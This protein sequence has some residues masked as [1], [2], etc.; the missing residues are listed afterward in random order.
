MI[1]NLIRDFLVAHKTLAK[2][3]R[4]PYNIG[5]SGIPVIIPSSGSMGN[6][7]AI[8]LTTALTTTY[9]GCYL[10]LPANAISAGSAA[11]FYYAVMSSTTVGTVYNNTYSSGV[12][13]DP[14]SPTAFSTTGP[15][16]YTQTTAADLTLLNITIP[17]GAMGKNGL[18][19]CYPEFTFSNSAGVKNLKLLLNATTVLT[20][21]PTT[22]AYNPM[23]YFF[24]NKGANNVNMDNSG[25][26]FGAIATTP[27]RR[28][29]D[30]GADF[31]YKCVG[32]LAAATDYIVLEA[33]I[34]QL[35]PSN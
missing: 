30:T 8:T 18:L 35:N 24:R 29:I 28:T 12:P 5:Q 4:I 27:T 31:T 9:P 16:A 11:G 1:S 21:S 34:I 7:G 10:Y 26:G 15:G 19:M 25:V 2:L 33:N 13:L 23:R 14:A 3:L 22:T 6:N 32:N 20:S 17:G